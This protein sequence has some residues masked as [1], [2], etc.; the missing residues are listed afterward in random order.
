MVLG[1]HSKEEAAQAQEEGDPLAAVAAMGEDVGGGEPE[2]QALGFGTDGD[3]PCLMLGRL[4]HPHHLVR[5]REPS[6]E[7]EP[8][9]VPMAK[10]EHL[11]NIPSIDVIVLQVWRNTDISTY[12]GVFIA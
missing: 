12:I 2:I 5:R 8:L 3:P 7:F 1:L 4:L 6:L 11:K 9:I 10:V